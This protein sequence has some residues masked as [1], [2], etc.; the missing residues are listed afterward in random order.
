MRTKKSL[1]QHFLRDPQYVQRLVSSITPGTEYIVEIGPGTGMLTR[2]L[3]GLRA[4]LLLIEKDSV[5]AGRAKTKWEDSHDIEVREADALAFDLLRYYHDN[6]FT[7]VGNFPYNI[8]SQIVFRILD[9][10][11]SV[12]EMVGMFQFEVARRI[13][14]GPGSKEY[15]ILSVLVASRYERELL[16]SVPPEAFDPPPKVTSAVVRLTRRSDP[17][18]PCGFRTL[19]RVVRAAFGQR[20][21]MLRNSL[22]SLFPVD[23]LKAPRFEKRPEH[24]HPH[25][26]VELAVALERLMEK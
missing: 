5:L 18:L 4:K 2:Y 9:L 20:R 12:P 8:S 7:V 6:P 1:G 19:Q 11:Q 17:E 15:G 25:E 14:A 26:F 16:F 3:V 22:L 13:V 23:F 10:Y 21:K 24:L